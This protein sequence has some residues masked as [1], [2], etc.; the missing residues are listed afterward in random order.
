MCFWSYAISS[1]D[2][3]K[4]PFQCQLASIFL[5]KIIKIASK[6]DLERHRF[7]IDLGANLP[8]FSFP[9]STKILSKID[10]KRHLF[11]DR[12]LHRFFLHFGSILGSK[13]GP[14]WPHFPLK[15]GEG[16]GRRPNFCWVYV[17]FR[18]FGRPGPLLAQFGFDVERFWAPCCRFCESCVASM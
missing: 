1:Q 7:L 5:P 14:C 12:F 2:R 10:F 8:P 4:M 6:I 9:K 15:W 16:V 18:F 11:F 3:F 17:S 13:L